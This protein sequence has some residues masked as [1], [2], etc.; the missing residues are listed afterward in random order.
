MT[1][2]SRSL[3]KPPADCTEMC[4]AKKCEACPGN[5]TI[6]RQ[7]APDW[8]APIERLHCACA[9]HGRAATDTRPG[10][11]DPPQRARSGRAA[12]EVTMTTLAEAT[13]YKRSLVNRCGEIDPLHPKAFCTEDPDHDG[14]HR[15]EYSGWSWP[16]KRPAQA[17]DP[18]RA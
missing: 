3:A 17:N 12:T 6:R 10:R 4:R 1:W 7:S 11:T 14:D 18:H 9:C 5:V 13:G 16:Q 15:H 8:E 2:R